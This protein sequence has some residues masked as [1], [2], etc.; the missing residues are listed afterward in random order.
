MAKKI[1]T[2]TKKHISTRLSEANVK[3]VDIINKLKEEYVIYDRVKPTSLA[4]ASGN[5]IRRL[6][7]KAINESI[8]T[9]ALLSNAA[10]KPEAT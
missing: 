10:N 5:E 4:K 1:I 3:S 9:P 7:F 8:I 2:N 6:P